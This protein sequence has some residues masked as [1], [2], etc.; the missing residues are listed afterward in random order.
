MRVHHLTREQCVPVGVEEAFAFF[1]DAFNLEAITPW[2]LRF[3]VVTGAPI[4]MGPG[5]LIEYGLNLH[6]VPVRWLTEITVWEPGVRFVDRQ[7]RGPYRLWEH[8]HRFEPCRSGTI[9]RDRV[10]YRLPL[11][12]LGALAHRAFVR[13]DL[14]R[15]FDFRR[16]E[17]ERRLG[18]AA[19]GCDPAPSG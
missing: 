10:R 8:E 16:R 1:A 7:V 13:R 14:E 2:R 6:G 18:G 3:R 9:I 15:I 17:V 4:A 12:L 5:T 19:E 11:G